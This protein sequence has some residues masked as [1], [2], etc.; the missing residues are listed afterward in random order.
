MV[1]RIYKVKIVIFYEKW[2]R[3]TGGRY[4][5]FIII[6]I[7]KIICLNNGIEE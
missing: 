2:N 3:I 4:L 6:S 1:I 5:K 7:Y